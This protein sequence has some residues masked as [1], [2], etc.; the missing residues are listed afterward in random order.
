MLPHKGKTV[1]TLVA[2]ETAIFKTAFK[3][4][5]LPIKNSVIKFYDFYVF[6]F[7]PFNTFGIKKT[8]NVKNPLL[9]SV[10]SFV[11]FQFN[12]LPDSSIGLSR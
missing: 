4:Q 12:F 1:V 11:K 8:N 9:M 2:K 3:S 10:S 6:Q 5:F 7:G